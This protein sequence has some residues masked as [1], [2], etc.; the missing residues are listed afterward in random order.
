MSKLGL[1][2]IASTRPV[3]GSIA[4]TAPCRSPSASYA[5]RCT[6]ASSV[7]STLDPRGGWPGEDAFDASEE[8][9][10]GGAAQLIVHRLLDAGRRAERRVDVPGDGCPHVAVD[11]HPLPGED[12]VGG[13]RARDRRAARDD[14]AALHFVRVVQRA[15][16]ARILRQRLGLHDLD[17]ARRGEQREE[18]QQ[19]QDAEPSEFFRHVSRSP[20]A[21]DCG[22][23]PRCAA[24]SRR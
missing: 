7:S 4:M 22:R 18:H 5:A 14:R 1:V 9:R 13:H 20:P 12:V 16:V 23:H 21:G 11:V 17:H 10:A 15:R 3:D 24:G 8:L 6:S 19:H 2:T